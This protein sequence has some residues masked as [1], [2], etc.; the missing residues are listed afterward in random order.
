[1]IFPT[2]S[3]AAYQLF[4]ICPVLKCLAKLLCHPPMHRVS[5]KGVKLLSRPN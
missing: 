3:S 1:L 2:N 4:S 5:H